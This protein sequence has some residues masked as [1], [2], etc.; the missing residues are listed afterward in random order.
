MSNLSVTF[1]SSNLPIEFSRL[2]GDSK[3][4]HRRNLQES[5][6]LSVRFGRR[7]PSRVARGRHAYFAGHLATFLFAL[8]LFACARESVRAQNVQHSK[9]SQDLGLRHNFTVDPVS[10][11]LNI[12]ITLGGYNGRGGSTLPVALRYSSKVWRLEYQDFKP[13]CAPPPGL[14]DDIT[15]TMLNAVYGDPNYD[16]MSAGWSNTLELPYVISEPEWY[17][18]TG[19]PCD[20]DKC[21]ETG[22]DRNYIRRLRLRMP[23]GSTHEMRADDNI[24]YYTQQPTYPLTY[25]AVD[26]SHI[27]YVATGDV[28]AQATIYLPDGSRYLTENNGWGNGQFIDRNGNTLTYNSSNNTWT[29]SLGRSITPASLP[30]YN[31]STLNFTYSYRQLKVAGHP[32]QSALTDFN[33]PL[34]YRG[35]GGWWGAPETYPALFNSSGSSK[36]GSEDLF[37]PGVLYQ[38]EAP[39]GR[40]YTFTYNTYGEIDKIVY[41]TGGYERFEYGAVPGVTA[42][43]EPYT[44]TNRGVIKH[45]VSPDGT[46]ASEKQWQYGAEEISQTMLKTFVVAPNGTVT[47][48]FVHRGRLPGQKPFGFDDAKSGMVFEETTYAQG[49]E[50]GL[51]GPMLRRSLTEWGLSQYVKQGGGV[52]GGFIVSRD[53][54]VIKQVELLLDTGGE[55]LASMTTL[56]HDGD[57]N[58]IS[59]AQYDYVPINSNTAQT[60]A[61][62]TIA[63]NFAQSTPLRTSE[64]TYLVNDPLIDS[65][66]QD[67]YRARNLLSLPSSTRTKNPQGTIVAEQRIRYD[68]TALL[69]YGPVLGWTDPG[70][71]FRGL[72][73]SRGNKLLASSTWIETTTQYDQFGNV[74]TSWDAND[75]KDT[76]IS[77]PTQIEYSIDYSYAYPT[78]VISADPDG[79]G[80]AASLI[81][82]TAYD[83]TSGLVTATWD[84]NDKMTTMEYAATDVLGNA[85]PLQR[86]TKVNRPDGGWTAY[87][88]S[89][90]PG[91]IS[92]LTRTALDASRYTEATQQFDGLGRPWRTV[93]SEGA[94]NIFTDVE[95]DSMGRVWKSSNPYRTLETVRWTITAFD[96]LGR[97][98]S[99]T[100]PDNAIASTA[101][102]GNRILVTDQALR[103]RLS[104]ADALGRLKD[105]WEVRTADTATES[106]S[107]PGHSEVTAGYRTSYEYDS[108][109]N[110]T[111][112]IQGTQ[113]PRILVYDSL[114]RLTSASNPESGAV[115]YHYDDNGNL[116]IKT[117]A[118]GV[119]TH[120]SY[121]A[122]N[123][124]LRRWYNGSS[125]VSQ[126]SH[127]SPAL[128]AGVGASHEVIYSY[129]AS[130][131]TNNGKGRL[132]S[133]TSN[134]S[135]YSYGYYDA[136][137]RVLNGTQTTDGEDYPMSYTYDLAGNMESQTY[138]S[139]RVVT[140]EFDAAG[141]LAGVAKNQASGLY[142]AGA[143]ATD[144]ANRLQYA[145]HGA[146][147]QMRL[148]NG[149]WEHTNFN[150]RLQPT[151]L[152]LGTSSSNSSVLQ[153][154]YNYGTTAN[155]GNVLSQTITVP[156]IGAVTGFTATQNYTYDALNRLATAQEN[157]GASWTQNFSYD[158]YGNRNFAGGTTFPTPLNAANNPVINPNNNRIDT[159]AT[160]QTNYSYDG[161]G[162]LTH[163]ATIHAFVYDA[164]NKQTT[165]D[166]GATANGGATY[167]YDG[168]G[169]RVKKIV[170]G[171]TIVTTVF[172]YNILGQLVA[173]YTNA[174]PPGPGGPSYLTSDTLGTPRVITGANQQVKARHDYLPFG[175]E[176]GG[177]HVALI[178][179]RTTTQGYTGDTVR[180]KFTSK[181]RDNETG[182]DYFLARYYSATQGR[183]T[184]PDSPFA[185]QFSQ[186]PQSWNLYSYTRNNPLRVADKDGRITPWDILDI[187]S[188]AMSVRDFWKQPSLGNAGWVFADLIG[189][190]APLLPVGS[191]RRAKQLMDVVGAASSPR[192]LQ[193]ATEGMAYAR[194]SKNFSV[195]A[196]GDSHVRN[197]VGMASDGKVADILALKGNKF[198]ISEV[199]GGTSPDISGALQQ[200]ENTASHLADNVISRRPSLEISRLE[201]VVHQGANLGNEFKIS[202]DQL[203][204]FNSATNKFEP[205]R[206][207]GQVVHVVEVPPPPVPS[208]LPKPYED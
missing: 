139:G 192:N 167:S 201:V 129:D 205:H 188:L 29:D 136:M 142:Y 123:R 195:L 103:Q 8:L 115:S 196:A 47:E 25:Y 36:I 199:K 5:E 37:N 32:E 191:I 132:S 164:E 30:G 208:S 162:N 50:F 120:V 127:N 170:G 126:I 64:G 194:I 93:Q 154:D 111:K 89:D 92:V 62:G 1:L 52:P 187:V 99:V 19:E 204:K 157:S 49:A 152:G 101:Y 59:T 148:G 175:E 73:T 159:A 90:T 4:S 22:T 185:D 91:A 173:E 102:S 114:K 150:F 137:G 66:I 28:N 163:D 3:L 165:Y 68:E 158:R 207:R 26:G 65:Q 110:L 96:A 74:R 84:A 63:Q 144:S 130:G 13:P 112:V 72:P 7:T 121:D 107:F 183:F 106:I 17:V 34:A 179:G 184:S 182:L 180:Q 76:S 108:L 57:L 147:S 128:P 151:Q 78:R 140:S 156:T 85:N 21:G 43:N 11:S 193:N 46:A 86:L 113:W 70:T 71:N 198:L 45:W 176:I 197:A 20:Y 48:R 40:K 39:G 122:L 100:T 200:L 168:D 12:Q 53:P 105:I 116:M 56:A 181:E 160:G 2:S 138:P 75:T 33:Q 141:R 161:A 203:L 6:S 172:V 143:A 38:I 117:D 97:V 131:E 27:R 14:C 61:I 55:A 124:P 82:R 87:G 166:G 77:N 95:Y 189:A 31:N 104:V 67:A 42:L 51:K 23:D 125:L 171:A 178:G 79:G 109:D 149:L 169:R 24:Y 133:V 146:P 94:T 190:A 206:I 58:V 18:I 119:S 155:N 134:V 118:R 15:Y 83:F 9:N 41:P 35:P 202:G 153:L 16:R 44:L 88:Y 186:N 81:T 54:R 145:A 135:S 10:L 69:T 174:T 177:P 80:P 98:T 60:G